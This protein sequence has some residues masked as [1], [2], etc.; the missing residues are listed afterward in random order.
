MAAGHA[1][2]NCELI[3][4][5]QCI[6]I[7]DYS[8]KHGASRSQTHHKLPTRREFFVDHLT[9][10]VFARFDMNGF[11]QD[12]VRPAPQRFLNS[13]LVDASLVSEFPI[14]RGRNHLTR[15][16]TRRRTL[17]DGVIAAYCF[18]DWR[19]DVP[20]LCTSRPG[21][22]RAALTGNFVA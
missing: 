16:G 19:R 12:T 7:S 14:I 2:Q 11:L 21:A 18:S 5:L 6:D 13:V 10:I 4:D 20:G 22:H 9:S 17:M 15:D 8:R 3:P 1:F